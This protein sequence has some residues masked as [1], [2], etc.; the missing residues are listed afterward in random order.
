MILIYHQN[1]LM[2]IIYL[3]IEKTTYSKVFIIKIIVISILHH[4]YLMIIRFLKIA[5]IN[6]LMYCNIT[7]SNTAL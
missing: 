1:K 6:Y 5:K 3:K 4:N 7:N 2:E